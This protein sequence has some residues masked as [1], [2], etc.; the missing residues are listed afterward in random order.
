[1]EYSAVKRQEVL[2]PPT[3]WMHFE[4]HGAKCKK[5][6]IATECMKCPE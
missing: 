5:T 1:M 2:I 4:K 3:T 6:Q